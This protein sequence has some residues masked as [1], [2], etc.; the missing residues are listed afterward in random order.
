MK[1]TPIFSILVVENLKKL[2]LI[3]RKADNYKQQTMD[4]FFLLY[5]TVEKLIFSIPILRRTR[6]REWRLLD[7]ER[8]QRMLKPQLNPVYWGT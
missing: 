4:I 7:T 5:K 1:K 3:N 6:N 2:Q 8:N